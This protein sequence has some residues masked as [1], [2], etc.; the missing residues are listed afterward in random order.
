MAIA[1]NQCQ[2]VGQF[3]MI[4]NHLPLWFIRTD[5]IVI[6]VAERNDHSWYVTFGQQGFLCAE[7]WCLSKPNGLE[8]H[9]PYK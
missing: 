4:G 5:H 7:A 2:L 6:F 3:V 8:H 9:F 1:L